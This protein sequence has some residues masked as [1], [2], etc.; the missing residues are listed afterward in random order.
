VRSFPPC[1]VC[2]CAFDF[3]TRPLA[4]RWHSTRSTLSDT[5][6]RDT[7]RPSRARLY[8]H[9]VSCWACAFGFSYP[10]PL[11]SSH[12]P[13]ACPHS[14]AQISRHRSTPST[15]RST[16]SDTNVRRAHPCP[17]RPPL[18]PSWLL[19]AVGISGLALAFTHATG[20][21]GPARPCVCA[22]GFSYSPPL[23]SPHPPTARPRSGAPID[24]L[25]HPT[26]N[27]IR[28][29]CETCPPPSAPIAI[30][31]APC[32]ACVL[33]LI[34]LAWLGQFDK[35][36]AFFSSLLSRATSRL[37]CGGHQA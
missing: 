15:R 10:P 24:T 37:E 29:Q 2:V 1:L 13:T 35:A 26:L 22:F 20:D 23:L 7:T 6:V 3:L 36:R 25:T 27:S 4:P 28:H 32:G 30:L 17:S 8:R 12:P 21:E 34:V 33:T 16:L 18:S 9:P 19:L 11:L 31:A 14:G 5:K